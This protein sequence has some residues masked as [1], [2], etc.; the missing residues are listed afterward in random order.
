MK[1]F[2]TEAVFPQQKKEVSYIIMLARLHS[3]KSLTHPDSSTSVP[4][5]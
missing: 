3:K 1:Y 2:Y 5:I 4:R